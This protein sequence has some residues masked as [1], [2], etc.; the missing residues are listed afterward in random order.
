MT[1]GYMG[2]ILRLDLTRN[3]A[4]VEET[5]ND[6]I[7]RFVGGR[8]FGIKILWDE[9]SPN[10]DP[11][12]PENKLVF[13]I[14]PLTATGVHS[15]SRW[16]AQ[17]K[18]PLTGTYGRSS[19]GGHFGAELKF[20]G[21]DAIIV[22]GHASKP[23]YVWIN[24]DKVEFR[25]SNLVWGMTTSNTR[26]FLRD[27]TDEKARMVMIGPAGE[28]LVKIAAIVTDNMRTA[29]RGGGGAVM[30]SK[31]LKAIVVRGTKK[32]EPYDKEAL[33]EAIKEQA[34]A[35]RKNFAFDGFHN[36]G[37]NMSVH[38]MYLA[39]HNPTFNFKQEELDVVERFSPEVL[40]QYMVKHDGCHICMIRCW[41]TYKLTKG[42]YAGTVSDMPEYETYF[43]YGSNTGNK[44]IESI[45]YAN[46]LSDEYGIDT[47]SAGSAI[48]FAMELYEKGIISKYET[49][50]LELRWG[51]P[52][53][54]VEL[55]KRIALRDGFGNILAEGT[56]KA[57]EIIGRGAEKYAQ[58]IKGL[59]L[60]GYDP[61]SAK[62]QGL[63]YVT[64]PIGA[65]H[66]IG[67][68]KFEL[69]GFAIGKTTDP[70]TTEGKGELT[71]YCQDETA[72]S[73]TGPICHFPICMEMI[74]LEL[75]SK[76]LY[77]ATGIKEFLDPEYLWLV[78]E[79]IFN[80]ERAFNVQEGF[81]RKDDTAPERILREPVPRAPSKGQIF[82]L[83]KLLDDYYKV[84]GWDDKTGVPT[85]NKFEELGLSDVAKTLEEM[86]K[87]PE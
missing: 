15:A 61:R 57:A 20:A 51:D 39:G 10:I 31:N 86:G 41:K 24:G 66:N 38:L 79:R 67:W 2:K 11:L 49:D 82:E 68:N 1:Y 4:V 80:L 14:G 55:V 48:A 50:G 70:L 3:K 63:S 18:S 40:G 87:L 42:A 8:G 64:S 7:K 76:L 29:S 30:G 19:G 83:K 56:K 45:V 47:I 32:P 23:T 53:V 52:D 78:G 9:L 72:L 81:T 84:R 27:E 62:A 26:D 60:P 17:F 16:F 73:E 59:E 35:Y 21:Y 25:D 74:T 46:K 33:K 71:K 77:A 22:E 36:L 75:Y 34:E 65:S 13:T 69:I 44:N 28:R 6:L 58:Q 37:T 43:A 5:S 85:K 54:L 12:S